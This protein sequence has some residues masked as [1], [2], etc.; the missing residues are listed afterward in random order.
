MLVEHEK[1]SNL[2]IWGQ[3]LLPCKK[4]QRSAMHGDARLF[5]PEHHHLFA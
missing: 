5:V 2:V 3:V 1:V 4:T